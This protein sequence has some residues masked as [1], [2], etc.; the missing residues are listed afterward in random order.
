MMMSESNNQ[1]MLGA[2]T[3]TMSG[4][5][6]NSNNNKVDVILHY[7]TDNNSEMVP[8]VEYKLSENGQ[9]DINSLV[10][11]LFN[12]G[13]DFNGQ[14]IFYFNQ[15][16]GLYVY[17]GKGPLSK[18]VNVEQEICLKDGIQGSKTLTLKLR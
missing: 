7:V 13:F 10:D 2:T 3:S 4:I 14:M 15:Q 1:Q 8:S 16:K 9:V 6:N 12:L 5:N 17:C 18:Q 11:N